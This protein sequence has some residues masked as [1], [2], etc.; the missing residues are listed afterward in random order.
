MARS[1]DDI[2]CIALPVRGDCG[3]GD[4]DSPLLLLLHE[5]HGCSPVIDFADTVDFACII[6][7]SLSCCCFSCVDMRHDSDIAHFL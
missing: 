2:D 7:N 3:R 4:G 5:V 6:E 1:V